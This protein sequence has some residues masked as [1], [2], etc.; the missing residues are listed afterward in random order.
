MGLMSALLPDSMQ[1]MNAAKNLLAL[2]V[3]VVGALSYTLF[4]FHRINW[5]AAGL[6]A[7]GSLAGGMLGAYYGRR[8]P[9]SALRAVIV[10]I[11]FIGLYQLVTVAGVTD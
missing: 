4:A 5:A 9:P 8:M 11:G 6:I 7:V 2:V 3:N 1:R 10:A